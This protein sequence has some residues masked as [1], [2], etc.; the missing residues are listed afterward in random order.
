MLPFTEDIFYHI[1]Q[2]FE[3]SC[4]RPFLRA[5]YKKSQLATGLPDPGQAS[6]IDNERLF[7][8]DFLLKN[9]LPR[10]YYLGLTDLR[11]SL[12]ALF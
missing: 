10:V 12:A 2:F 11:Y 8:K 5:L 6:H 4:F 9:Y 3:T 1:G 7:F